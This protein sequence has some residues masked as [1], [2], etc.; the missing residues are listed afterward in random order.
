MPGSSDKKAA[1]DSSPSF[2]TNRATKDEHRD[3]QRTGADIKRVNATIKKKAQGRPQ[4]IGPMIYLAF[5]RIAK[6]IL[7]KEEARRKFTLEGMVD[8][9]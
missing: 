3:Y 2:T 9:K 1:L 7:Q 4:I 5:D 6:E 8:D